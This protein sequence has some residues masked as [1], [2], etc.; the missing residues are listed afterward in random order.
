MTKTTILLFFKE[1]ELMYTSLKFFK[2]IQKPVNKNY[3]TR[4]NNQKICIRVIFRI[5]LV[6]FEIGNIGKV[7]LNIHVIL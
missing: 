6:R 3:A 2:I 5:F 4:K 7:I 1:L